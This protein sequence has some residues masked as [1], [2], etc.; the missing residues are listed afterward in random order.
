MD[1]GYKCCEKTVNFGDDIPAH[2]DGQEWTGGHQEAQ[3]KR[4]LKRMNT[5]Q[6]S[7]KSRACETRCGPPI[8]DCSGFTGI[9]LWG[10]GDMGLKP[11]AF[12]KDAVSP[13]LKISRKC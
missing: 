5:S 12:T 3:A 2:S 1:G 8:P 11:D 10:H 9:T 4:G 13:F 6:S 7:S